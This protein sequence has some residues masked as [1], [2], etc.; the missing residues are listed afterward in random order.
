M[1][2]KCLV[3]HYCNAS[4]AVAVDVAVAVNPVTVVVELIILFGD[5]KEGGGGIGGSSVHEKRQEIRTRNSIKMKFIFD[6]QYVVTRDRRFIGVDISLCLD[7]SGEVVSRAF[8]Q[9]DCAV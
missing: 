2:C 7:R 4:D 6:V 1:L 5:I 8:V 9:F 3:H